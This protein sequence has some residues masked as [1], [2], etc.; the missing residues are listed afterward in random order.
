MLSVHECHLDLSL[1]ACYYILFWKARQGFDLIYFSV[2]KSRHWMRAERRE[3]GGKGEKET[4]SSKSSC[5]EYK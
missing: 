1:H 5:L 4:V 2:D 3:E